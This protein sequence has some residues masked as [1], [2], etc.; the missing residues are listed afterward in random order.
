MEQ[1]ARV[2]VAILLE[3]VCKDVQNAI[4]ILSIGV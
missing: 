3:I 1:E 4:V 2:V